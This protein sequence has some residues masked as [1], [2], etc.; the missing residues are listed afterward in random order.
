MYIFLTFLKYERNCWNYLN[1]GSLQCDF[2]FLAVVASDYV[3][4][5]KLTNSRNSYV[6]I[7]RSDDHQPI[8]AL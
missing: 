6:T 7:R 5:S 4:H 8:K 1:G 3:C 2:R